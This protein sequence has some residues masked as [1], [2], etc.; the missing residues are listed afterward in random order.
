[1]SPLKVGVGASS[2]ADSRQAGQAAARQALAGCAGLPP[3]GA[4]VFS[5][6]HGLDH[7]ELLAGVREVLGHTPL[8]GGTTFG[9]I[10][11]PEL[12]EGSVVV[13]LLAG[14]AVR[15]AVGLGTGVAKDAFAA[16]AQAAKA[17]LRCLPEKP[18]L[19][20][21]FYETQMG[22]PDRAV[23]G[24][25]SVLGRDFPIVGAGT[26]SGLMMEQNPFSKQFCGGEV[27]GGCFA[28]LLLGG[29]FAFSCGF[30]HGGTAVS[31]EFVLTK[32]RDNVVVE[33]DGRPA[34]DVFEETLG[35]KLG[36]RGLGYLDIQ[37]AVQEPRHPGLDTIRA[38][39]GA[40]VKQRTLYCGNVIDEGLRVKLSQVRADV[41]LQRQKAAMA[42]ARA[43]LGG[44]VAGT[45][46]IDCY[47]RKLTL[48]AQQLI[49][50]ELRLIFEAAGKGPL[51]GLYSGSECVVL[52]WG[53]KDPES[54]YCHQ[55]T[56][57]VLFG[58]S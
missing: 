55:S 35:I 2:G 48:G 19:F 38:L 8:V 24:A 11:G 23:E 20:L 56:S 41:T 28:G 53:G 39:W 42:K 34:L 57:F 44:P 13:W 32:T 52:D 27:L 22:D 9:E 33:L 7:G 31:K 43:Q 30:S 17:A 37:L 15:A 51:A 16:G 40:D 6:Y 46:C 1:M 14:R 5:G 29:D 25:K 10:A 4:V 36:A 49:G 45:L 54:R 47:G 21:I 50:T 3:A 58:E 12:S 26:G 18:K